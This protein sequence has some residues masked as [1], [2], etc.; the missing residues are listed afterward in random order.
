MDNEIGQFINLHKLKLVRCN[1]NVFN[2]KLLSKYLEKLNLEGNQIKDLD[3]IK[4]T[5]FANMSLS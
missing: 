2:P 4:F 3:Q 5:S 1:L